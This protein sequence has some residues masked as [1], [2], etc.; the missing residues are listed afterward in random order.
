MTHPTTTL[1]AD[2]TSPTS[3]APALGWG[4]PPSTP[5]PPGPRQPGWARRNLATLMAGAALTISV[6]GLA[7]GQ[8]PG[9]V[10]PQGPRGIQG[11]Q[12][13]QGAVGPRGEAGKNGKDG[14]T[15]EVPAAPAPEAAPAT[16]AAP[17]G[18]EFGEGTYKVGT[19]IQPGEYKG[20]VDD[21]NGYWARLDRSQEI[22][23]NEWSTKTGATMYFT[24]RSSDAYVEISGAT[25]HKVG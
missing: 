6:V 17:T 14:T 16:E 5:T 13:P 21:G 2:K 10:G 24:V 11:V 8:E 1:P 25:F 20:T 9:P 18:A 19:D 15:V 3:P 12:G 7:A 22:I 4:R 23:D